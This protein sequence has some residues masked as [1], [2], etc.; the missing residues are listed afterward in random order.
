MILIYY[1]VLIYC[2]YY[3]WI[4]IIIIIIIIIYHVS[5]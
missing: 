4:I 2:N 5:Y 1:N 3:V